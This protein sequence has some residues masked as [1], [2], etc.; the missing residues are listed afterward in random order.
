MHFANL[1]GVG[2]ASF[3][4]CCVVNGYG[5]GCHKPVEYMCVH[6]NARHHHNNSK[7]RCGRRWGM[8]PWG[9]AAWGKM[10]FWRDWEALRGAPRA[11]LALD[12]RTR[13]I[14]STSKARPVKIK[15]DQA[16]VLEG[17]GM[18][19]AVPGRPRRH[20]Q[21]QKLHRHEEEANS[22]R[23]ISPSLL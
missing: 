1:I 19:L 13:A 20:G 12:L 10:I 5:C 23:I 8:P 4:P 7:V 21:V 15:A 14:S 2:W 3:G 18:R 11:V 17:C 6:K 22:H 9:W 16:S